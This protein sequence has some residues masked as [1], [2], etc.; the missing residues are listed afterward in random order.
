[1]YQLSIE[2]VINL[3][4]NKIN[5]DNC[6]EHETKGKFD[7][8]MN[9]CEYCEYC[10]DHKICDHCHISYCGNEICLNHCCGC[11]DFRT[12]FII[13]FFNLLLKICNDKKNIYYMYFKLNNETLSSDIMTTIIDGLDTYP[14]E[15]FVKIMYQ[16][17]TFSDNGIEDCKPDKNTLN[18]I[19]NY[20]GIYV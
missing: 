19:F 6:E 4:F 3:I 10:S 15:E 5:M 1:M 18:I 7:D 11:V 16:L 14:I 12:K 17:V 2:L 20:F 8:L 9:N 13:R